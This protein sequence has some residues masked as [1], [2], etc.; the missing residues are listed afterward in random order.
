M[1]A[2]SVGETTWERHGAGPPVVLIHGF[3]LNR[4]MWQWMLPAL[5]PHSRC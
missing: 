1:S 2:G 5:T 4:A 3:G